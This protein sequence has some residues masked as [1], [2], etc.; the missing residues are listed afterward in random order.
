M[1]L[2]TP[3]AESTAPAEKSSD[4]R[5][6]STDFAALHQRMAHDINHLPLKQEPAARLTGI[7]L[8]AASLCAAGC[9]GADDG[10]GFP[11]GAQSEEDSA[12]GKADDTDDARPDE[13][14]DVLPP[15][16]RIFRDLGTDAPHCLG[17]LMG[18]NTV[19]TA[20]HCV[21]SLEKAFA[22]GQQP[23]VHAEW[24]S[25]QGDCGT[26]ANTDLEAFTRTCRRTQAVRLDMSR[27]AVTDPVVV[28]DLGLHPE[29]PDAA[30]IAT[31]DPLDPDLV[32]SGLS[33][34]ADHCANPGREPF[35]AFPPQ[36]QPVDPTEELD[37][38]AV[39]WRVEGDEVVRA[40]SKEISRLCVERFF[41]DLGSGADPLWTNSLG[42]GDA[43]HLYMTASPCDGG[44]SYTLDGDSG[45]PLL[46]TGNQLYTM[47]RDRLVVYGLLQGATNVTTDFA[48]IGE[49][50]ACSTAVIA[51]HL[52]LI[53]SSDDT[54]MEQQDYKSAVYSS[55]F[56]RPL[57]TWAAQAYTSLEGTDW[58]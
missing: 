54:C 20:A 22:A 58:R 39:S 8:L 48:T 11:D 26:L 18:C 46:G 2:A 10:R 52:G 50:V 34:S 55:L 17:T 9:D 43:Y 40:T 23:S 32:E 42:E 16:V 56:N 27:V 6:R 51:Q 53:E 3:P 57:Q 47:E 36:I 4:Q 29:V 41:S 13:F 35:I 33:R 14:L 49:R 44:L 7:A 31:M 21:G 25:L 15:V 37:S 45:G 28:A 1:R 19:L 38:F 30:V 24:Y 5:P 12:G